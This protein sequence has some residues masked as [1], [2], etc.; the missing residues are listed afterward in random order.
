MCRRRIICAAQSCWPLIDEALSAFQQFTNARRERYL[1]G[2]GNPNRSYDVSPDDKRFLMIKAASADPTAVPPHI[3]VVLLFDD[4][5]KRLAATKSADALDRPLH[6]RFSELN[7]ST[8]VV[9]ARRD[10]Y[11]RTDDGRA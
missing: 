10:A 5:L 8:R 6:F 2:A 9:A 11:S 1:T 7:R 4:E 3:I